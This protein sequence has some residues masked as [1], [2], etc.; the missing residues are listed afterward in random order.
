ME[1]KEFET[2]VNQIRPHLLR[3]AIRYLQDKDDAEDITQEVL[4]KLWSM[5]LQLEE[6]RSVEALALV[7]T[8]HLCL[9]RLR[10]QLHPREDLDK[11][12]KADENENPEV[13]LIDK[14]QY[15]RLLILIDKLPDVQQA[16][17]RMKHIDGMEI[18]EIARITGSEEVTV[19]TNLSRARKKIAELF[20]N[21]L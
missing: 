12:D 3:Q 5:R 15:A 6:Y 20:I 18:S 17:L 21:Q 9:N 19:R 10:L 7:I 11:V 2:E 8:K 1:R 4:L 16:T 14:E 13:S